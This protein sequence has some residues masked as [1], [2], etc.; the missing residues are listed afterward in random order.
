MANLVASQTIYFIYQILIKQLMDSEVTYRMTCILLT[1]GPWFRMSNISYSEVLDPQEAVKGLSGN[2]IYFYNLYIFT[3]QK[4][5]NKIL[6][7]VV[8]FLVSF[9]SC[10][11]SKL[12]SLL[13][14]FFPPHIAATGYICS[15]ED[16]DEPHENEIKEILNLLTVSELHD[17]LCKLKKVCIY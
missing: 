15:F 4:N 9:C 3:Y 14:I 16:K 10:Q 1:S 11:I 17:I 2:N 8:M 13:T 7:L 6:V 5:K 12:R